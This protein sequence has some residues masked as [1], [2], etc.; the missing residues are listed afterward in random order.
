MNYLSKNLASL[1]KINGFTQDDIAEKVY[2][3][4]QAVSKWERGE[5]VPDIDTLAAL[6]ELYDVS[7]DDFIKSDLSQY[8]PSDK[9]DDKVYNDLKLLR[10]KQNLK[11]MS[12]W[13]VL[14]LAGYALIAGIIQ[15]ALYDI[16][17][18]E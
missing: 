18:P 3:S 5:S 17:Q 16:A 13:A 10:R 8:S 2:V 9:K 4:R 12:I 14:L 6:S 7:L 15:V 1:R 11:L